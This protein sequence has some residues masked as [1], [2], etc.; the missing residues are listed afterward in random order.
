[1]LS[2]KSRNVIKCLTKGQCREVGVSMK[3]ADIQISAAPN[4]WTVIIITLGILGSLYTVD[5]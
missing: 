4:Q 3:A 5:N 2:S 1:M